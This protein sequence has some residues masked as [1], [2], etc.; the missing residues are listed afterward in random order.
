MTS[1]AQQYNTTII[2]ALV[3]I[4]LTLVSDFLLS[5]P[6]EITWLTFFLGSIVTVTTTMLEQKLLSVTS[7]ELNRKLEIYELL[8]SIT[9]DELRHLAD[10][11]LKEYLKKLREYSQGFTS[12]AT[13]GYLANRIQ[14][15]RKSYKSTF[16]VTNLDEIHKL[17]DED[18][19]INYM[20]SNL[21]A[22]KRGVKIQ[23][24]F[25]FHKQDIL[26]AQGNFIDQTALDIMRKQQDEGIEVRVSWLE[27]WRRYGETGD[28]YR[29]FVIIDGKEVFTHNFGVDQKVMGR[30]LI[31][32]PNQV[33]EYK[34]RYERIWQ[35]SKPLRDVINGI[36][37]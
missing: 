13:H 33:E 15:C 11:E 32:N 36:N 22:I 2:G 30:T 20:R 5:L 14:T 18:A 34:S 27:D 12:F 26:D 29:D 24:V 25:I 23:R 6:K 3:T 16:W 31:K 8:E 37:E 9:D 28:L 4:T 17:I 35:L 1:K 19:G 21:E 10:T 7:E